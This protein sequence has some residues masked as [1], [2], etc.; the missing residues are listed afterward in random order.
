MTEKK[1]GSD[2]AEAT[3]TYAKHIEGD[4]FKMYGY[5]WFT[6]A[7][8]CGMTLA[9]AREV[10]QNEEITQGTKGISLFYVKMRN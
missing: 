4:N 1:G 3:E 6:S 9:L 7:T 8:T 2:V 10:N 5:K